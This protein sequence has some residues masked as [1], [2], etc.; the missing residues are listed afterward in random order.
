MHERMIQALQTRRAQIRI[1]WEALLRIEKATTPLANP[2]TL[3]FA[4][5]QSLDEIFT[6]L[7]QPPVPCGDTGPDNGEGSCPWRA[8]YRAGE[9]ALLESLILLQAKTPTLDPATRDDAFGRLKQ[10]IGH[11]AQREVSA[12]SGLGPPHACPAAERTRRPRAH[13][14]ASA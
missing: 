2:D 1:R 8:Y 9:Q 4:L 6:A 10:V 5:D 14:P 13:S 11:L 7:R 12:W 3:V